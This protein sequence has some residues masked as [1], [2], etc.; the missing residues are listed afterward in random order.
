VRENIRARTDRELVSAS[1]EFV[2]DKSGHTEVHRYVAGPIIRLLRDANARRVLDLGC[3]NGALT[4][5]LAK[6]GFQMTGIDCSGSGIALARAEFPT[7]RFEQRELLAPLESE[8]QGAY[9]GVISVEVIEHLLLPR[10]LMQAARVAL[11]P[12]GVF[13]L[14]TPFH[15]YWKN[16]ALAIA[17]KFDDHWHPLRDFGHVKFFSRETIT[18]LFEEFGFVDC[19]FETVGRIPA[20]AR[21]MIV[22]GR[23]SA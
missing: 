7:T 19:G 6:R 15:G 10:K 18:S 9:D 8:H 14:T 4:A 5:L 12:R 22:S 11:R 2:W 20:L 16:L 17:G 3:G 13:V 21:S 23:R 1:A